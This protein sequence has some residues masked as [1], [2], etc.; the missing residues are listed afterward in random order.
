M[1]G[2]ESSHTFTRIQYS[3]THHN[4]RKMYF[5]KLGHEIGIMEHYGNVPELVCSSSGVYRLDILYGYPVKFDIIGIGKN[6]IIHI[7]QLRIL[8]MF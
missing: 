1:P 3:T 7:T 2:F 4:V 6:G 5:I 8:F